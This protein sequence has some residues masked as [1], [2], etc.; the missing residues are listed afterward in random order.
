MR[1]LNEDALVNEAKRFTGGELVYANLD[2]ET[3]DRVSEALSDMSKGE[4]KVVATNRRA[5]H[6]FQVV[7]TFECGLVLKGS[8]V[9][10]LRE[11]KVQLAES[12]ARISGGARSGCT[13]CTCRPT[14]M[15]APP[16]ATIPIG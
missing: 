5:R 4:R 12:Y 15:P 7:D 8:E 16:S 13:H 10:S 1:N 11:S 14:P 2:E 3:L 6:E 9:K